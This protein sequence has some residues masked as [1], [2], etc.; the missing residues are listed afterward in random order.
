MISYVANWKGYHISGYACSYVIIYITMY[1]ITRLFFETVVN[2][3]SIIYFGH[4]DDLWRWKI[5][6]ISWSSLRCLRTIFCYL[7][8]VDLTFWIKTI[9]CIFDIFSLM[10][11]IIL[12]SNPIFHFS[13][14]CFHIILSHLIQ[15]LGPCRYWSR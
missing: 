6:R 7:F 14:S 15:T 3:T 11:E 10:N 12:W 4:E 9:T 2:Q 1:S 8:I 13:M 5:R